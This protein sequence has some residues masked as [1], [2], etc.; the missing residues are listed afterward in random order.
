M[1]LHDLLVQMQDCIA[2]ITIAERQGNLSFVCDRLQRLNDMFFSVE[3]VVPVNLLPGILRG[4]GGPEIKFPDNLQEQ[5]VQMQDCIADVI[6]A[7]QLGNNCLVCD[8]LEGLNDM[9]LFTEEF[10][11]VIY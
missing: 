8:R 6:I 7:E 1:D 10:L 9:L 4:P 11:P 2:D 3:Q 5:F